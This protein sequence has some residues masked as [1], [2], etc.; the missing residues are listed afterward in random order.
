MFPWF[1]LGT[2]SQ[3]MTNSLHYQR[4]VAKTDS[5]NLIKII[6]LSPNVNQPELIETIKT[7]KLMRS[8]PY[9]AQSEIHAAGWG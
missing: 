5:L 4:T 6:N 1:Y 2:V 7:I 9:S 3:T 8:I